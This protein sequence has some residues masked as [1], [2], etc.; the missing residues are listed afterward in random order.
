MPVDAGPPTYQICGAGCCKSSSLIGTA[1]ASPWI[2]DPYR[3]TG[4]ALIA[5]TANARDLVVATRNARDF[6][7]LDVEV[8]NPWNYR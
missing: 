8:I 3:A 7:G 1:H 4:H 5:G 6:A 2:P